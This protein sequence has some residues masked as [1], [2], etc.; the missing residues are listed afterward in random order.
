MSIQEIFNN[1]QKDL[2]KL[3]NQRRLW[4]WASS[5][6]LVGILSLIFSWEW[7]ADFHSKHVWW[8]IVSV[9]LIIAINWWY[10]TMRVIRIIICYQ[11]IEY[12][13]IKQLH[14]EISIVKHDISSSFDEIIGG[15]K[16]SS[17]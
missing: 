12:E 10:W 8:L 6:V 7:L 17:R 9:M 15:L 4:L 13:L 5:I 3:N 14:H 16:E 2:E 11:K 1:H